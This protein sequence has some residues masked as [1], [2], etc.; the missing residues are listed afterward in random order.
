MVNHANLLEIIPKVIVASVVSN[1]VILSG[2]IV[3]PSSCCGLYSN[4]FSIR[5]IDSDIVLFARS[6][7]SFMAA[8]RSSFFS[9]CLASF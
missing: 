9:K 6:I 8:R 7:S 5:L 3:N 2:Y 1:P 4:S